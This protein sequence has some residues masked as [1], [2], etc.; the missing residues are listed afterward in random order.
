MSNLYSMHAYL[1]LLVYFIIFLFQV[2]S[3]SYDSA[4]NSTFVRSW[5]VQNG[6]LSKEKRIHTHLV[7]EG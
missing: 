4:E 3:L 5:N 1:I 7:I 2:T 6:A